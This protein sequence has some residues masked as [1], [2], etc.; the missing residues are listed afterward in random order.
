MK[1]A[2]DQVLGDC[3][4]KRNGNVEKKIHLSVAPSA[5]AMVITLLSRDYVKHSLVATTCCRES[6]TCCYVIL[7]RFLCE[8]KMPVAIYSKISLVLCMAPHYLH[9]RSHF[10]GIQK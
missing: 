9:A 1:T 7:C 2:V 4:G 6:N 5:K 10:K 8:N 3:G